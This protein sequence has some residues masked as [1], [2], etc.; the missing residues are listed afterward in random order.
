MAGAVPLALD[1]EVGLADMARQAMDHLVAP[2]A[3]LHQQL[4]QHPPAHNL[5]PCTL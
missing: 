3:H 4:K 5:S 2:E 1:A